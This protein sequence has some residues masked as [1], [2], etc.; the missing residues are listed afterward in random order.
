MKVEVE[1]LDSVRKKV[2]VLLPVEIVNDIREAVYEEV[3][4]HASIKGFRPGK[5]PRNIINQY[6]KEYIDEETKK[7]M[8]EN[9][10]FAALMEAKVDPIIEPVVHFMEKEGEPGYSLDCEVV[11]EIELP[12]Y[13]GV[14]IEVEPMNVSEEDVNRRIEGLQNMHAEIVEKP[15][16][17]PAS[18]GDF[19]II[20]YQGYHNGEPVKEVAAESYPLELGNARLMPEFE[21]GLLGMKEN[22]EK[23]IEITFPEDYPDPS[24]AT[25][26]LLF[27][28]TL[29]EVRQKRLPEV[30]DGFAKDLNFENVEA[31]KDGTRSELLKEKEAAR[32]RDIT[33]KIIETLLKDREI[34][35]PPRVLEKRIADMV[36]ETK[37]RYRTEKYTA[38][39]LVALEDRLKGEFGKRAED[40]LKVEIMLTRIAEKE[41]IKS[42]DS[43][44]EER[45]KKIAEETGKAYNE[46][47]SVYEQYNLVGG[48]RNAIVEDKTVDFLKENAV[49]KE[50]A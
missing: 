22:E 34:P 21:A 1:T 49:I 17:T 13:K 2:E 45:M 4:K 33:Q 32:Q 28:V 3:K 5:I 46:V 47:R 14:E 12:E 29:K 9:T 27:K 42:E 24:I 16:D 20:K 6:Y 19:V 40:R 8:V 23:E 37:S 7:K 36:E 25:K 11:P 50:K 39:E 30:N 44:V 31:L 43:D 35:V 18:E 48:L 10:M 38:Q 41:G 15:G 26:T